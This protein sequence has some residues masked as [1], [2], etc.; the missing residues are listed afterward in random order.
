[1]PVSVKA[2]LTPSGN[3]TA[4]TSFTQDVPAVAVGDIVVIAVAHDN[5]ALSTPT[6]TINKPS[7][8]FGSWS[9]LSWTNPT[10]TSGAGI[11]GRLFWIRAS[12]AWPAESRT[13]SLSASVTAKVSGGYVI[14]GATTPTLSTGIASHATS[15]ASLVSAGADANS[16]TIFMAGQEN[17]AIGTLTGPMSSGTNDTGGAT[18]GGS[19]NTNIAAR[20]RTVFGTAGNGTTTQAGAVDKGIVYVTFPEFVPLIPGTKLNIGD[21]AGKNH[22]KLAVSPASPG[23]IFEKTQVEIEAGYTLADVFSA[24][25]SNTLV[26]FKAFADAAIQ[27]DGYPGVELREVNSDDSPME[28]NA[29]TGEHVM[30]GST[31]VYNAPA[32]DREL[33]FAHLHDGAGS[34]IGIGLVFDDIGEVYFGAWVDD[35]PNFSATVGFW[36]GSVHDWKIRSVDGNVELYFN[37]LDNPFYTLSLN[38]P[39]IPDKWHFRTGLAA[40]YKV[41]V[42]GML[43]VPT[44]SDFGRVDMTALSVDHMHGDPTPG[45][46]TDI[47]KIAI[48]SSLLPMDKLYIGTTKVNRVYIGTNMVYDDV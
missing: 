26:S 3:K 13:V 21:D 44:S 33:I 39:T 5:T 37:D 38:P 30:T 45:G 2:V 22:F 14:E 7:G 34:R 9:S 11:H 43:G 29:L 4:G 18:S 27:D 16:I 46:G 32:A 35:Q 24:D 19:A 12:V 40:R 17:T 15:T 1:M 23:S 41:G 8:E 36:D 6:V 28:F 25:F 10:S 31:A 48:G 47:Q 20:M 42:S